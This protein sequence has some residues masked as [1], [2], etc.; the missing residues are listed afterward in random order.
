MK[1]KEK[2]TLSPELM[3]TTG[4]I[5]ALIF[6]VILPVVALVFN[7]KLS[8]QLRYFNMLYTVGTMFLLPRTA[9]LYITIGSGIVTLLLW[10]IFFRKK[11]KRCNGFIGGGLL[12]NA[13]FYFV[14]GVMGVYRLLIIP[15]WFPPFCAVPVLIS[16]GLKSLKI[17]RTVISNSKVILSAFA[18]AVFVVVLS[19]SVVRQPWDFV[20]HLPN[21]A[22][23]DFSGMNLSNIY[24]ES[25]SVIT[26]EGADFSFANL[27]NSFVRCNMQNTNM[28]GADLRNIRLYRVN[29]K[30]ANLSDANLN[31][32]EIYEVDF[33]GAD[34]QGASLGFNA[35]GR[36]DM[37]DANLCGADLSKLENT[38]RIYWRDGIRYDSSTLWPDD[39][40]PNGFGLVLVK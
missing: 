7:Y 22:G 19:L 37:S 28:K 8:Q 24:I 5:L 9:Y 29:L 25:G 39:F 2:D 33:T 21:A 4:I 27:R 26:F 1:T 23:A 13:L 32:A 3:S 17:A 35:R 36:I 6:G 10:L 14:F 38:D 15:V 18:G 11:G 12:F 34:F 40:D 30:G 20:R 31:N 16:S